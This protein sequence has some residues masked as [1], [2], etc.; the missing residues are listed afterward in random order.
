MQGRLSVLNRDTPTLTVVEPRGMPVRSVGYCRTLEDEPLETRVNRTAHDAAGRAIAQWDPRLFLASH[1]ESNLSAMH[2]LG[3]KVLCSESVDAGLRVS[4]WGEAGQAV[5]SRDS[6]GSQRW[7]RYDD[8]LR[9]TQ[10]H[11]QPV[12]G[13]TFCIERLIYGGSGSVFGER[14]QCG[15]LIRHDDPAGTQL[16]PLNGITGG[17]LQQTRHFLREL[18]PI[19]WPESEVDRDACL[20]PGAGATTQMHVNALG[21]LVEQTDARSNRQFFR[22]NVAGQLRDV[23]LQL[24]HQAAPITLVG[25]IQY[26]AHG[27]NEHEVAGNGVVTTLE[28]AGEDGRLTRLKARRGADFLQDLTYEYDAK[29]NVLRIEDAAIP[30]R[31]F[32]NQRIDPVNGYDYDSLDQLICASGWEAGG[33]NKGPRFSTFDDP[34]PRSAYRQTYRYDQGGNLLQLNHAGPQQHGHRLVTALASNRCLPVLEDKEPSEE[35]FLNGFDGN[36]NLLKLQPGQT[37]QWDLRNQLREVRPVERDGAPND[38]EQYIYGADGLRLRKIR[39]TQTNARTL[40]AEVRYLPGLEIRTHSGTGEVLHMI[41]VPAGRS[42]VRVLH[43][44]STPP[45]DNDAY[46]FNLS[47]QLG[48]CTMELDLEGEVISQ[49]RYHPFGTTAWFAGRSEIEADLKAVRYSGKERDATGLYYYG[50][51]YYVSWWQRWLNPD[52]AGVQ[53]GLNV[54]AF[55]RGNPT[56]FTDV[57][58]LG[59]VDLSNLTKRQEE[60]AGIRGAQAI[61][62]DEMIKKNVTLGRSNDKPASYVYVEVDQKTLDRLNLAD[63]AN[64]FAH[65][66][67]PFGSRNKVI[68]IWRTQNEVEDQLRQVRR[69]KDTIAKNAE[70]GRA[71]NCREFS[72]VAY[73]MLKGA[74]SR[75]APL[76][77][78]SAQ[79]VDHSIVVIGDYRMEGAVFADSWSTFPVA[80]LARHSQYAVGSVWESVGPSHD[81]TVDYLDDRNLEINAKLDFPADVSGDESAASILELIKTEHEGNEIF[82]EWFSVKEESNVHYYFS[83]NQ[84]TSPTLSKKYVSER[85]GH[86]VKLQK[87]WG[88]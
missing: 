12:H 2:G 67:L 19:D 4:L 70:A 34:A 24:Q 51:R 66:F 64:R 83:G 74:S 87:L 88:R 38:H 10:L 57:Q 43:W 53:D 41:S 50:L 81:P 8:Q 39:S 60:L 85:L 3:G 27:Q 52:P 9:L 80:H 76:F 86:A 35:D 44:E 55:V 11:E 32:A 14:N 73:D 17:A 78:I 13:H 58:G 6:R 36:G 15:Q 79:G 33:A 40:T 48:S 62:I 23:H 71:G 22:H 59:R 5:F 42:S 82:F 65:A 54:F 16:F 30:T 69:G 47:D 77:R 7:L 37:L 61:P 21:E 84:L 68:D 46:R 45:A 29:G 49:E 18:S 75:E 25:A 72:K 1:A 26:N 20:E 63:R 31:Y 56:S 28:Y